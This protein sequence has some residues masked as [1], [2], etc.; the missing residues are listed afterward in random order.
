VREI[1]AFLYP[2][3]F[4]AAEVM[5]GLHRLRPEATLELDDA[6]S[7][8]CD[9]RGRLRLH[10]AQRPAP[11]MS[12]AQFWPLL[13]GPLVAPDSEGAAAGARHAFISDDAFCSA[14]RAQLTPGTSA[15]FVLVR[16]VTRDHLVPHLAAFGGTL[17][18]APLAPDE[19]PSPGAP[20]ERPCHCG[21]CGH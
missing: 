16:D 1:V 17:L 6:V 20:P 3:T 11:G 2:D 15:V 5:A 8:T 4:R 18:R 19:Q 12:G 10:F 7:V 9:S 21:H 13:I 14:V